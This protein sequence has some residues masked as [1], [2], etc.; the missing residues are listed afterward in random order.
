MVE[1]VR[2]KFDEAD[3]L[4]PV[5]AQTHQQ[6][7]FCNT[8]IDV[9][10]LHGK[11]GQIERWQRH[12]LKSKHR[13]NQRI[14]A[15]IAPR[16]EP[17][18]KQ[19]ERHVLGLLDLT[20]NGLQ[21]REQRC[22]AHVG[23]HP[24]P[25]RQQIGKKPNH[26]LG[27]RPATIGGDCANDQV[28]F[29]RRSVHERCESRKNHVEQRCPLLQRQRLEASGQA[30]VDADRDQAAPETALPRAWPIRRQRQN[31]R[32]ALQG[33]ERSVDGGCERRLGRGLAL[34]GGEVG[35]AQ[36]ELRQARAL[37]CRRIIRE[38][39]ACQYGQRPT[40]DADMMRC[41]DERRFC[42][43]VMDQDCAQQGTDGEIERR[44]SDF[45]GQP[46]A[47]GLLADR[48]LLQHDDASRRGFL[49]D[50]S[51]AVSKNRAQNVMALHRRVER[52]RETLAVESAGQP[53]H[54][55][56][57]ICARAGAGPFQQP[58]LLLRVG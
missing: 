46:L 20:E 14:G 32:S 57:M 11:P 13:L 4:V 6:I 8:E 48:R 47:L 33:L 42:F 39:I 54:D 50:D 21:S 15:R 53:Q 43:A 37:A 38:D 31:R 3:Q 55:G 44:K 35:V 19:L 34:P 45:A 12:V 25:D 10:Q 18:G 5:G 24:D 17:L 58:E 41:Q 1:Q 22:E 29:V 7:E 26:I 27:P 16:C 56:N 40:V 28:V 52:R 2:G 36:R 30:S 9:D 51:V 23:L 49:L